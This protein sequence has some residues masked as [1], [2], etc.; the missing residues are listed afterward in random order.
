MKIEAEKI[1]K[2][3]IAGRREQMR[4]SP[5]RCWAARVKS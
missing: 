1:Q 4:P 5:K 3:R 2:P